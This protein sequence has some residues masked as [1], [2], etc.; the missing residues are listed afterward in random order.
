MSIQRNTDERPL[1]TFESALLGQLTAV[2]DERAT[3]TA[4]SPSRRLAKRPVRWAAAAAAAAAGTAAFLVLPS[5]NAA[6]AVDSDSSGSVTV[7]I[8]QLEGAD[9]LE[10]AL[11]AKGI[12]ADVTYPAVGKQCAP[13]RYTEAPRD[14]SGPPSEAN[15]FKSSGG[16]DGF[17]MTIPKNAIK[18]GQTLVLESVWPNSQTWMVKVG[19]ASGAVG[20]CQPIDAEEIVT[21]PPGTPLPTGGGSDVQPSVEP[22]DTATPTAFATAK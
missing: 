8:N 6:Y 1:D 9:A 4:M 18:P 7:T 15:S 10:A 12:T 14:G 13:G 21:V 22:G 16:P 17:T 2:V 19:I 20:A 11:A 5:G 3:Q